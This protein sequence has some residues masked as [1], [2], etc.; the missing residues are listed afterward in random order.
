M[1]G[2][3][4]CSIHQRSCL[5]DLVQRV[6]DDPEIILALAETMDADGDPEFVPTLE[7]WALVAFKKDR[8]RIRETIARIQRQR[9]SD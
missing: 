9:A 3:Q 7:T 5:P 2:R 1:S 4:A 8:A 6:P